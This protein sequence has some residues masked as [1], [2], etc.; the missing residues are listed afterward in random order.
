MDP[1]EEYIVQKNYSDYLEQNQRKSLGYYDDENEILLG[2]GPSLSGYAHTEYPFLKIIPPGYKIVPSY[3]VNNKLG[4]LLGGLIHLAKKHNRPIEY[5]VY[6]TLG[7][8]L[9]FAN[10]KKLYGGFG[11]SDIKK[12]AHKNL[13]DLEGIKQHPVGFL[14]NVGS[15]IDKVMPYAIDAGKDI[16]DNPLSS[17]SAIKKYF[18]KTI[19][20][21]K[22]Y[23]QRPIYGKYGSGACCSNC[24]HGKKC[25][26]G[27]NPSI[28]NDPKFLKKLQEQKNKIQDEKESLKEEYKEA[29]INVNQPLM[30]EIEREFKELAKEEAAVNS[31]I[32]NI[33]NS[34]E[35]L[36]P[37]D[38]VAT[39][40]NVAVNTKNQ[41]CPELDLPHQYARSYINFVYPQLPEYVKERLSI[42]L[43][44]S[45]NN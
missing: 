40:Y 36:H 43:Y 28:L 13:R 32:I 2:A 10:Y 23:S 17:L 42:N 39:D 16:I 34:K 12:I 15:F 6:K 35:I 20:I 26:G 45:I 24:A 44:K 30:K 37:E 18:D 8:G 38:Y 19:P 33:Q 29:N 1:L 5:T 27:M 21:A 7:K 41:H 22:Q 9:V 25:K 11:M 14:K 31:E 3:I 4:D